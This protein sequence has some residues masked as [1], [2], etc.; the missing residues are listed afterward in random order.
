[1]EPQLVAKRD[2]KLVMV[3]R[4]RRGALIVASPDVENETAIWFEH[5]LNFGC[6]GKEPLDIF[7]LIYISIFFFEVKR[8]RRRCNDRVDSGRGKTPH[9]A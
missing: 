3:Q 8:V 9:E 6:E 4:P 5:S 1:M 7:R 2:E